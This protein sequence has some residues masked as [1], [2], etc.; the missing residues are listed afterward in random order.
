MT[1]SAL[2][3]QAHLFLRGVLIDR[4]REHR[5]FTGG[6]LLRC[7]LFA[8]KC[9]EHASRKLLD[10]LLRLF[11]R[12]PGGHH[13]GGVF[14]EHVRLITLRDVRTRI[15]PGLRAGDLEPYCVADI[16]FAQQAAH[17]P[18]ACGLGS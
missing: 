7:R 4:K 14:C 5:H 2:G 8:L 3:V 10:R 6:V 15:V 1:P 9:F 17:I 13:R 16:F 12:A 11:V 18:Q